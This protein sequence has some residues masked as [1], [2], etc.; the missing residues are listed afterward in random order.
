[1]TEPRNLMQLPTDLPIPEDDGACD[2]LTG[3]AVPTIALPSTAGGPVNL[4]ETASTRTVVYSEWTTWFNLP[5]KTTIAHRATVRGD[6][7]RPHCPRLRTIRS[8]SGALVGDHSL[9]RLS[10]FSSSA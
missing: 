8:R 7:F 10:V 1:M 9:L 2:H 5:V 4:A 6:T 3:M